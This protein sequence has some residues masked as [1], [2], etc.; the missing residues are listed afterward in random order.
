MK[1]E[2]KDSSEQLA[3]VA[4]KITGDILGIDAHT[5]YGT[6]GR[7]TM[8]GTMIA[9]LARAL[10]QVLKEK[11]ESEK[12]SAPTTEN[13]KVVMMAP[14]IPKPLDKGAA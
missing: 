7:E 4:Q 13:A 1:I 2:F 9:G 12:A 3:L 11:R 8:G 10:V 14:V 6:E 5:E